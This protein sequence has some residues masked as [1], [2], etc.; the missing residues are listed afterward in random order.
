VHGVKTG[1][2]IQLQ[3]WVYIS[4]EFAPVFES[5]GPRLFK[6]QQDDSKSCGACLDDRNFPCHACD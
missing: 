1:N 2:V 6:I 5:M 3:E 4:V